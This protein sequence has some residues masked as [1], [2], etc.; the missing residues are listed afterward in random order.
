MEVKRGDI[1]AAAI[2]GDYGGRSRPAVVIQ[3]D[4]FNPTHSSVVVCPLTTAVVD[5]PM[6]RIDLFPTHENGLAA[7]SQIMADKLYAVRREKIGRRIGRLTSA[8]LVA[9]ERAIAL[10]LG[11]AS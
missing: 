1:V 10:M 8:E 2:A 6:F 11:L 9:A 3:S 7:Q 4:L 5:A